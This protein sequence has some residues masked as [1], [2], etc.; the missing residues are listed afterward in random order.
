MRHR[1][2]L[3]GLTAAALLT[4]ISA[5]SVSSAP[6]SDERLV[7]LA[8]ERACDTSRDT[9]E[10]GAWLFDIYFEGVTL[11]AGQQ[12]RAIAELK[13]YEQA[14]LNITETQPEQD[15]MRTSEEVL[16]LEEAFLDHLSPELSTEQIQQVRQN[17]E[18]NRSLNHRTLFLRNWQLWQLIFS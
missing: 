12:E 16:A 10:Y 4:G 13:C 8:N 14:F 11:T 1:L 5:Y 15:E 2:F 9:S 17:V 6:F 7:A 3:S 18:L